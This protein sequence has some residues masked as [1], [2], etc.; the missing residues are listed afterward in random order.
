MSRPHP[1]SKARVPT[2]RVIYRPARGAIWA[3]VFLSVFLAVLL[4]LDDEPGTDVGI[5]ETAILSLVALFCVAAW[6]QRLFI[7]QNLEGST[8]CIQRRWFFFWKRSSTHPIREIHDVALE[9]ERKVKGCSHRI[10]LTLHDNTRIPITDEFMD[11]GRHHERAAREIRALLQLPNQDAPVNVLEAPQPAPAVITA[12]PSARPRPQG[13]WPASA[14]PA[15]V[16]YRPDAQEWWHLVVS[17]STFFILCVVAFEHGLICAGVLSATFVILAPLALHRL[18]AWT[19]RLVI[20]R[21]PVDETLRVVRHR[22]LGRRRE[23]IHPLG[24]VQDVAV[25]VNSNDDWSIRV[26]LVRRDGYRLPICGGFRGDIPHHERTAREV[27]ALLQLSDPGATM[28]VFQLPF[29]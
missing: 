2:R 29:Y 26:V 12:S 20:T 21:N 25:E 5:P 28:T 1:T 23:T 15:R 19:R 7:T 13:G 3:A 22:L 6:A 9:V 16:I 10:V 27:R 18:D 14:P 11:D 8:L 17:G 24:D 4:M